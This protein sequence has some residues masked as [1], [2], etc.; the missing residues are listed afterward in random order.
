MTPRLRLLGV[1]VIFAAFIAM[2]PRETFWFAQTF[3]GAQKMFYSLK[4]LVRRDHRPDTWSWNPSDKFAFGIEQDKSGMAVRMPW[5]QALLPPLSDRT[6]IY[7]LTVE[8]TLSD[9][10]ALRGRLCGQSFDLPGTV[11][12]P[13][14]CFMIARHLRIEATGAPA[15]EG[16]RLFYGRLQSL[17]LTPSERAP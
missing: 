14:A 4:D 1:I 11:V 17:S 15:F 16:D 8:G 10:V 5:A 13:H 12:L 9:G 3:G 2:T 6:A 7:T